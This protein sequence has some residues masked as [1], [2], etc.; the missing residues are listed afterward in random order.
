MSQEHH[1]TRQQGGGAISLKDFGNGITTQLHP[2]A[3]AN[4]FSMQ[5]SSSNNP[6]RDQ[7]GDNNNP[8]GWGFHFAPPAHHHNMGTSWRC[9]VCWVQNH[10]PPSQA[11]AQAQAQANPRSA[12]A[13]PGP[14]PTCTACGAPKP[15]HNSQRGVEEDVRGGSRS[16]PQCFMFPGDRRNDG[17]DGDSNNDDE[18][19]DNNRDNSPRQ[20]PFTNDSESS[21]SSS[22]GPSNKRDAMEQVQSASKRLRVELAQHEHKLNSF[23]ERL[24]IAESR[25]EERYQSLAS[26]KATIEASHGNP[27]A[28]ENDLLEI[29]A[30]GRIVA[31]RR[32]TLCQIEGSHLATLFSGRYENQLQ[33]DDAGR[34]FLDVNPKCFRAIVDYLNYLKLSP[35][36]RSPDPP[37]VSDEHRPLLVHQIR[38]FGL[39]GMLFPRERLIDSR[40]LRGNDSKAMA[41]QL[42]TWMEEEGCDGEFRLLYRSSRD[43][44]AGREF[45]GRCDNEG[46]TITVIKTNSG[47]IAG[48]YASTPWGGSRP[49]AVPFGQHARSNDRAS[50]GGNSFVFGN[51]NQRGFGFA[52]PSFAL[53]E[54]RGAASETSQRNPDNSFLFY[55]G[56]S[57]PTKMKLK[58][59]R[60]NIAVYYDPNYGP[61]FGSNA[62]PGDFVFGTPVHDL[63]VNGT[64]LRLDFGNSYERPNSLAAPRGDY[65]IEEV[66]VFRIVE[67]GSEEDG[68]A[69]WGAS[70]A[71]EPITKEPINM[72]ETN[73]FSPSVNDALN[74]KLRVLKAAEEEISILERSFQEEENFISSFANGEAKDVIT[75]NVSGT[76]MATRRSTLRVFEESVLARQFDDTTW[77]EQGRTNGI[78]AKEWTPDDVA[79]WAESV[80]GIQEGVC[81]I[82][83]Q[84]AIT[85]R[86]LLTLNMEGLKMLGIERAGTLCLLL[87]EIKKLERASSNN[88]M[89]SP[90]IEHSPYCFGKILDYLR[91]KQLHSQGMADEPALP[92]VRDSERSRFEMTVNYFFPG[93]SSRLIHG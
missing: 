48:G 4:I 29:N 38:L 81:D 46:K 91:L 55:F 18:R 20:F 25:I 54:H 53:N 74:K 73:S 27:N 35:L 11:Q 76:P 23:V 70:D 43:G 60:Q 15:R 50:F 49:G 32:S 19:N 44:A 34:I 9:G 40:I 87:D 13:G 42:Y 45:H 28:N 93:E 85:G 17:L 77:T 62:P 65:A 84:N 66:E 92:T 56:G 79:S 78:D 47:L 36:E 24:D 71:G 3:A 64:S 1:T 69:L 82:L 37:C 5:S 26:A 31:A 80:E 14:A 30:G 7:E 86:E 2:R 51:G 57:P 39:G 52:Q 16:I 6:N 72:S 61:T 90:L 59:S 58:Q 67:R 75:L 10:A 12:G 88:G 68:A 63:R 89:S 21:S 83:K 33:R 22:G 8:G 41:R